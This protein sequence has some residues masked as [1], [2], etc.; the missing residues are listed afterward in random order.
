M[1]H[2]SRIP[3]THFHTTFGATLRSLADTEPDPERARQMALLAS[4]LEVAFDQQGSNVQVAIWDVQDATREK[5]ND[6]HEH[7]SDTNLLLATINESL[8]GLR[9]DVQASAAE[10]AARLGKL[11][12]GQ[13]ALAGQVSDLGERLDAGDTREEERYHESMADRASLHAQVVQLAERMA[14]YIAGS[15]RDE[16]EQRL[17]ALEAARDGQP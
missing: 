4:Q 10:S 1:T 6:L 3:V 14:A 2:Y 15:R 8:N 7:Q 12:A 11:E 17:A 13:D 5:I 16:F 9:R